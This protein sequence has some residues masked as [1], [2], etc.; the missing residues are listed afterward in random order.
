M[1]FVVLWLMLLGLGVSAAE[2]IFE[3]VQSK[4]SGLD[5]RFESGSRGKFDLPEIMG[6][7]GD[8]SPVTAYGV[9]MGIKASAKKAYGSDDLKGKKIAVQG[10]GKV[11][12]HLIEMLKNDGAILFATDIFEHGLKIAADKYGASIVKP[13][14]IFLPEQ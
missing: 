6:G 1:Q 8:P 2:P 9:Y 10:T 11:G 3:V 7:G 12:L 5:F 14:E 13:E 4:T